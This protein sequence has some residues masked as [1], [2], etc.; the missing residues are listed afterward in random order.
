MFSKRRLEDVTVELLRKSVIQPPDDVVRAL[1]KA[2]K[3]ENDETARTQ[4]N[5]I[6]NN[7]KLAKKKHVPVCQDTGIPLVYVKVGVKAKVD[8]N[9]LQNAITHGV[10][11]ATKEIPLRPN[12]VDPVSRKNSGNNI[13][14]QMPH[15]D[16]TFLPG[17]EYVELTVLPKGAGSENMSALK[18][19]N[20]SEGIK[21]V[22]KFVLEVVANASG[23]PCPPTIVGVGIGGSSDMAMTLAKK[24]ILRPIGVANKDK[25]LGELESE[26]KEKINQ[27]GI[28]PMG[29]GG[30]TTC[31]AVHIEKAGCHTASL[32]VGVNIQCWTGRRATA[33]I[34]GDKVEWLK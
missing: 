30:D 7:I 13:G 3:T 11:R 26:L 22:K 19:L 34:Y 25:K 14:E 31:L 27:L 17:K 29:L 10:A 21:G 12:V 18:M 4:L 16:F 32:P 15:I 20:P 1:E 28:G 24:A 33:R 9:C 23:N 2:C 8:L 6:L 5:V